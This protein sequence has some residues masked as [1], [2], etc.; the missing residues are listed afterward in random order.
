MRSPDFSKRF[1][2]S[3]NE[4]GFVSMIYL[5]QCYC[6]HCL[7]LTEDQASAQAPAPAPV[8]AVELSCVTCGGAH[9]STKTVQPPHDKRYRDNI[10]E[11]CPSALQANSTTVSFQFPTSQMVVNS[12]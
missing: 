3:F 7:L 11:L 9:S 2:E 1:V 5:G 4:V 6:E 10:S 12:Y 8:K